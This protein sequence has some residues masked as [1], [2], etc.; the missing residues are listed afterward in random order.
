MYVPEYCIR[1]VPFFISLI[2]AY[3]GTCTP[4]SLKY[5]P[6][7]LSTYLYITLVLIYH[8]IQAVREP[9]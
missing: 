1:H 8:S 3:L 9:E 5:N 7:S 4:V 2:G 6:V